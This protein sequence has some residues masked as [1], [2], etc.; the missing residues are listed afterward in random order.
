VLV[1]GL[2]AWLTASLL[3]LTWSAVRTVDPVYVQDAWEFIGRVELAMSPAAA[4]LA[5]RG[6]IW[7]WRAGPVQ[8]AAAVLLVVAA[9]PIAAKAL[10][11]W[12]F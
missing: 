6:A 4:V 5:A 9:V 11:G 3:F 10:G 12:I 8:R 2:G 1:L 7:G